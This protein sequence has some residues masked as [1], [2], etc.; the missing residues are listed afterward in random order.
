MFKA[1][2]DCKVKRVIVA[3]SSS[4]HQTLSPYSVSKKGSEMVA[5]M[6]WDVHNVESICLRFFNVFGP[7]QP[8]NGA[9]SAVVPKFID[10]I[11]RGEPPCIY[12]SG[13]QYRD[14]TYVDNVVEAVILAIRSETLPFGAYVDIGTGNPHTVLDLLSEISDAMGKP[15]P[16]PNLL[17]DRLGDI[18][19][20]EANIDM[21]RSAFGYTPVV[22]FE[23]GIN[24]TVNDRD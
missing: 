5:K 14:F 13:N 19:Y 21:A 18:Q 3:S 16:V 17:P 11:K 24:R 1:A 10:A 8:L 4:A 20:S 2:L 23:E 6:F 9:Y 12:G 7:G 15:M 22:G